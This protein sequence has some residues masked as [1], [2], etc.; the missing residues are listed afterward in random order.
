MLR[1]VSALFSGAVFEACLFGCLGMG[2]RDDDILGA[3]IFSHR[4]WPTGSRLEF[5]RSDLPLQSSAVRAQA[6][7]KTERC[8][9]LPK[10]W[11]IKL[12]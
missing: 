3:G 9:K 4:L 1:G 8:S 5:T 12:L 11:S 2:G 10:Q 6:F 7:K